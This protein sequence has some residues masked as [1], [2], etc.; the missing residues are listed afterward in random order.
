MTRATPEEV[1]A[2][3]PRPV[4]FHPLP[5]PPGAPRRSIVPLKAAGT[6]PPVFLVPGQ[7]GE[8][9]HFKRLVERVHDDIPVYGFEA[10][11]LYGDAEPI[12][13]TRDMA[14]YYVEEMRTVQPRGPHLLGGF[15]VGGKIAYEMARL[16]QSEGDPPHLLIFDYGPSPRRGTGATGIVNRLLLPPRTIRFHW[17]NY[18][19]LE[20]QRRAA[21][22]REQISDEIRQ[23]L[24]RLGIQPRDW[25]YKIGGP[26]P[27]SGS[28]PVAELAGAPAVRRALR[29]AENNWGEWIDEPFRSRFT[30]FRG[31]IQYPGANLDEQ[32]GFDETTAPGGVDVRHIPGLHAFLFVE[33]HVFTLIAEL[34][35]WVARVPD[36]PLPGVTRP[37]GGAAR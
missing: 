5:G 30:L 11:G 19:G 27:P 10:R 17:Q 8:L 7:R 18:R 32:L 25:F 6:T 24:H 2:R 34:E 3:A 22:R 12:D 21:Y 23:L 37:A 33:P 16:L 9:F 29:N 35:D 31:K 4:P 20:G 36:A 26:K 28:A 1:R 13:N 14:R 15:S